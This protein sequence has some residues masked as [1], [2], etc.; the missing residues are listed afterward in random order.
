MTALRR[1]VIEAPAVDPLAAARLD[2]FCRRAWPADPSRAA[3]YLRAI[4]SF[5]LHS[6]TDDKKD[7]WYYTVASRFVGIARFMIGLGRA[8]FVQV[9]PA[10]WY[11]WLAARRQETN[12]HSTAYEVL[13]WQRL[14]QAS[15]AGA[16]PEGIRFNPWEGAKPWKRLR[17]SAN[18]VEVSTPMLD[19]DEARMIFAAAMTWVDDYGP[20]LVRA[21]QA[22]ASVPVT[23]RDLESLPPLEK[24]PNAHRTLVVA[25]VRL[26]AACQVVAWLTTA[27]RYAELARIPADGPQLVRAHGGIWVRSVWSKRIGQPP[28][29]TFW[30]GSEYTA[31]AI[32]I[33]SALSARSRELT[34]IPMVFAPLIRLAKA[35]RDPGA[36]GTLRQRAVRFVRDFCGLEVTPHMFRRRFAGV[37]GARPRGVLIS[38]S[39]LKQ[40]DLGCAQRYCFDPRSAPLLEPED[41][42]T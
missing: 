20:A 41:R 42:P 30:A 10:D 19:I 6:R 36:T 16:V 31:R 2:Q 5:L 18:A 22:S 34:G 12:P 21:W 4:E 11:A 14:Y 25:C 3:P 17:V 15:A 23:W 35:V 24:Y 32:E 7:S 13:L 28:M 38:A 1:V 39:L 9:G 33:A 40:A 29:E 37:V 8:S 27:M 26:Q